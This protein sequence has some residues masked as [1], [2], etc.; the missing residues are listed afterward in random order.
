MIVT[1]VIYISRVR[2]ATFVKS[3]KSLNFAGPGP[4]SKLSCFDD[5]GAPQNV[6]SVRANACS[7]ADRV[8]N[9][10]AM[11][12]FWWFEKDAIA[13]LARPG[14][15]AVQ[16]F[17][18]TFQESAVLSWI[19]QYST[20]A[21]PIN[22][23]R[24]HLQTY[25]P[26]IFRFHGL[27]EVSGQKELAIF[28]RADGLNRALESLNRRKQLFKSYQVDRDS[29]HVEFCQ[30]RLQYEIEFLKKEGI[31]RLVTLTERHHAKDELEKHFAVHH[32]AIQDLGAPKR[33]QAAE[34]AVILEEA[35]SAGETVGI[36]CLAGIGRTSTMIMG[37]HILLGESLDRMKARISQANPTFVLAGHQEEFLNSL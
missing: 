34:L 35:A 12:A 14:F 28:D 13:G 5:S 3:N 2:D 17:D 36:H 10:R 37:A 19:G 32:I 26:R 24:H 9:V 31:D 1:K 16:W 15:N 33:E 30:D 29:L 11:R 8:G 22:S 23:F 7:V 6:V 4:T 21:A 27:D 25:I 20:G 18:L